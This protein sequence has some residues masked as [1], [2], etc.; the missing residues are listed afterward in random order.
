MGFDPDTRQNRRK[1]VSGKVFRRGLRFNGIA[2]DGPL[3]RRRLKVRPGGPKI[4][5]DA[6]GRGLPIICRNGALIRWRLDVRPESLRQ[7]GLRR[8]R[9]HGVGRFGI[10]AFVGISD[11]MRARVA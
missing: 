7:W 3:P 9:R 6:T 2:V 5:R 4:L 1:I 10:R 8:G 11:W